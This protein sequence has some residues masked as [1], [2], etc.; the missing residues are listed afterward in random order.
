MGIALARDRA[1]GA[2]LRVFLSETG[3]FD[4]ELKE[5]DDLVVRAKADLVE[6]ADSDFAVSGTTGLGVDEL[7]AA[8]SDVL[9][10]AECQCRIGNPRPTSPSTERGEE[11]L[12][13]GG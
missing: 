4:A 7:V 12:V 2:D 10:D 5:A 3:E 13:G 8:I 1:K 9:F 11:E 6:V